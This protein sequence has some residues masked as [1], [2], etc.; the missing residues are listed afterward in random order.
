[1]MSKSSL[2]TSRG[3]SPFC[4]TCKNAGKSESEYRSHFTKSNAGPTGVVIC[5]TILAFVC[6]NC[7]NSGHLAKYCKQTSVKVV[8]SASVVCLS[9]LERKKNACA[10][11][12]F[13]KKLS[14]NK[15]SVLDSDSSDSEEEE[16]EESVV[17]KP[18]KL[19]Y[20]NILEK[21]A[22]DSSA[23]SKLSAGSAVVGNFRVLVAG[24]S[25]MEAARNLGLN[26]RVSVMSKRRRWAD[27]VSSSEGEDDFSF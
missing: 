10:A 2:K 6:S 22:V 20:K 13:M 19:S 17:E 23:D 16:E 15:F 9:P 4:A 18:A 21:P 12:A 26:L 7:K 3:P 11:D 27:D 5:P 25:G 14:A 8:A 1:M 24:K